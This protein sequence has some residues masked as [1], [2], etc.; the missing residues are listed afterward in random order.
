M[1]DLRSVVN[2]QIYSKGPNFLI[3]V[4]LSGIALI[5]ML[6]LA[7]LML[8]GMGDK[9]VPSAHVTGA[10]TAHLLKSVLSRFVA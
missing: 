6:I 7:Y 3:V 5:F 8:F 9:L 4:I 1:S 2:A 10:A